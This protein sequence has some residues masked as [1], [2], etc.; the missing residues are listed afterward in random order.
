MLNL[1]VTHSLI[2]LSPKG[3]T[4]LFPSTIYIPW[5]VQVKSAV[6]S[7]S[8]LSSIV[9]E[10]WPIS[11]CSW[12][13]KTAVHNYTNRWITRTSLA[14]LIVKSWREASF[15]TSSSYVMFKASV[16]SSA[17][18]W[19]LQVTLPSRLF[20]GLANSVLVRSAVRRGPG[21]ERQDLTHFSVCKVGMPRLSRSEITVSWFLALTAL[22]MSH[23]SIWTLE[24][25]SAT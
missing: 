15:K 17:S 18:L 6:K 14:S 9:K 8:Y 24:D 16:F 20:M 10:L 2:H 3:V 7:A 23:G 13:Q 4:Q 25:N 21:G 12:W 1:P 11:N 5:V 22:G 19:S